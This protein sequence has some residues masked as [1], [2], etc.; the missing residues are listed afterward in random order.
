MKNNFDYIII[1]SGIAGL[2]TALTLGDSGSVAIFTKK[3]PS[4]S[5]TNLAQGGMAAMIGEGDQA[6]WHVEDTMKA[7]DF[8][9]KKRPFI[10]WLKIA[11]KRY[12]G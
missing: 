12:F 11:R 2:T 10:F 6:D 7:G 1:G 5:A 3:N 4:D 8:H 9:I